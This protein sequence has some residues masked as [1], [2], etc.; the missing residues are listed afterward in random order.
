MPLHNIKF[1]LD[2]LRGKDG[3]DQVIQDWCEP[4]DSEFIANCIVCHKKVL[5]IEGK[6]SCLHMQEQKHTKNMLQD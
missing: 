1:N 5:E 4:G 3:N 2:L 6:A